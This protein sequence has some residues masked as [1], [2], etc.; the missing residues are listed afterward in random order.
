MSSRGFDV[1]T[2]DLFKKRRKEK[3][4]RQHEMRLPK[5]DSIFIVTEG[6]KTEPAYFQALASKVIAARGGNIDVR[7]E[8]LGRGT[9]S[10]VEK[11]AELLARSP[12]VFQH[13]WVVFDKDDFDDFDEAIL[14]AREYGFNV[15]WSNQAFEYWLLL[16]FEFSDAALDRSDWTRKLDAL[17]RQR[18]IREKGYE[19]NL[20]DI[21]EIVTTFGSEQFAISNA[22]CMRDGFKGRSPSSCDPSTT[23][24]ELVELLNSF[25]ECV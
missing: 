1:G 11:A 23:V 16:H 17:F 6:E 25:L 21:Y 24:Y 12:K 10:L 20:S 8:G 7:I 3:K 9:T 4:G 18:G 19:K 5:A 14:L 2:D 15:A 13:V 22:K